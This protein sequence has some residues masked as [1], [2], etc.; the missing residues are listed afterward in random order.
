VLATKVAL[1][2]SEDRTLLSDLKAT[3]TWLNKNVED[4][5]EALVCA[6]DIP[7][8]LN[9][10]DPLTSEWIGNWQPA[11][12]LVLNLPE[13]YGAWKAVR[14]FLHEYEE[15]LLSAGCHRLNSVKRDKRQPSAEISGGAVDLAKQFSE[16]RREGRLTDL[17]FEP[18]IQTA[19]DECSDSQELAAHKAFLA[20]TLPYFRD[21]FELEKCGLL[22]DLMSS[23]TEW[24]APL[25][26]HDVGFTGLLKKFLE[27]TPPDKLFRSQ[28]FK[29][30]GT[31]FAAKLVLGIVRHLPI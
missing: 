7:L 25:N 23:A 13:D 17:F 18:I 1:R 14:P 4:A 8:F 3:Y 24:N 19:A 2:H 5:R 11:S 28:K 29:F 21:K 20:A 12:K 22:E 31:R 10:V 6:V 15:L 26:D 9:D 16:M 27:T 30:E